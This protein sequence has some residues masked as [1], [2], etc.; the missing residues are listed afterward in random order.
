M[1]GL[2]KNGKWTHGHGQHVMIVVMG[3]GGMRRL[4]T[5]EENT[6]QNKEIV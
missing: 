4:N 5:N 1:E 3:E 2:N 6:I